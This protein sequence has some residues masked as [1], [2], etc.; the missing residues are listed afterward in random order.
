MAG[1]A[2]PVVLDHLSFAVELYNVRRFPG[3]LSELGPL[4]VIEGV[5]V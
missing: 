5:V 3:V 1:E 4:L 2:G